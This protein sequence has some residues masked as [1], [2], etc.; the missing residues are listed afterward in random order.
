MVE[1]KIQSYMKKG[2]SREEA[3]KR[4]AEK[5]GFLERSETKPR[6]KP[7]VKEKPKPRLPPDI[8]HQRSNTR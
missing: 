6:P 5:E 1:R 8:L 4:L 7:E 3:I 2:L